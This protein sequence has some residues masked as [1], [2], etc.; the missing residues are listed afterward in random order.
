[1]TDGSPNP[2]HNGRSECMKI[3][4]LIRVE[5]SP[6][7]IVSVHFIPLSIGKQGQTT[8]VDS[9]EKRLGDFWDGQRLAGAGSSRLRCRS[10]R[11][12]SCHCISSPASKSNAAA[13]GNGMLT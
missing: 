5:Q 2:K 13:K 7:R 3:K 9:A 12:K 8:T 1:M 4:L 11:S 10:D 6:S